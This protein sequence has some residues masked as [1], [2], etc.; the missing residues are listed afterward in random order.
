ML[1][2][3]TLM[4]CLRPVLQWVRARLAVGTSP[5]LRALQRVVAVEPCRVPSPVPIPV[6]RRPRALAAVLA[7]ALATVAT[8]PN[9]SLAQW[10]PVDQQD[11]VDLTA[12]GRLVDVQVQV[13]G[14]G[15]V[16]LYTA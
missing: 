8:L 12:D 1:T 3:A 4:G 16:P 6:P 14:L 5:M 9:V 11:G 10:R 2:T 15:T 13:D 7:A